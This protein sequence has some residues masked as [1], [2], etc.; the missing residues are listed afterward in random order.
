MGDW[1]PE[2]AEALQVVVIDLKD[3]DKNFSQRYLR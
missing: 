3:E 1:M 2:I